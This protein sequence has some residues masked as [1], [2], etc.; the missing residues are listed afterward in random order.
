MKGLEI[1]ELYGNYFIAD[2]R[3]NKFLMLDLKNKKAS[4]IDQ[5]HYNIIT[6]VSEIK[7]ELKNIK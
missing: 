3:K 4:I 2:Y 6:L 7:R 5:H 1:Q